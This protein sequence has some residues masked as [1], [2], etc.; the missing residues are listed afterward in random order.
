MK[1]HHLPTFGVAPIFACGSLHR[2]CLLAVA[3]TSIL[4]ACVGYVPGRQSYWDAQIKEMCAN[5]GG[6]RIFERLRV[7]KTDIARL[8][9]IGEKIGIPTKSLAHP[10]APAYADLRITYIREADPVVSRHETSVIRRSDQS[11]IAKWVAYTRSGGDLP[12]PGHPSHYSCP[13][14]SQIVS[15]LQ[16]LFIVE[17][18]R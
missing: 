11:I 3:L 6:V 13:Q 17:T 10:D 2:A 18:D 1:K 9:T 12:G 16:Q 8:G 5:D 7:S 14:H 4:A 15:D